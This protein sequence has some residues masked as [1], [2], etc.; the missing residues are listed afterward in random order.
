MKDFK[1]QISYNECRNVGTILKQ[2]ISSIA[3]KYEPNELAFLALTSKI[4]NPLRDKIAFALYKEFG[5]RKIVCL[6]IKG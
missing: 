6:P 1:G 4:E 5:N 3:D 2:I